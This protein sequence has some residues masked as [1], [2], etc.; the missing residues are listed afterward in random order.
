MDVL[1]LYSGTGALGFEALS[2][3]AASLVSIDHDRQYIQAQKEWIISHKKPFQAIVGDV[4]RVLKNLQGSFDLIFADPPYEVGVSPAILRLIEERINSDGIFVYE[5]DK[6]SD[7]PIESKIFNLIK[8]KTVA[9]TK[10]EIY[11]AT[12]R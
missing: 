3:G 7:T 12:G 11:K 5:R 1:D 2:R 10:I 8:E 4:G 6:K 9:Q